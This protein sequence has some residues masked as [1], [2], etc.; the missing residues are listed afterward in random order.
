MYGRENLNYRYLISFGKDLGKWLFLY[1]F[2]VVG[3][4]IFIVCFG[5]KY[6]NNYWNLNIY[7]F[8]FINFIDM[9]FFLESLEVKVLVNIVLCE[10]IFNIVLFEMEKNNLVVILI[11][12]YFEG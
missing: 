3:W 4:W 8:W 10:R 6:V 9:N 1:I 7:S 12:F 2:Y 11:I 5:K